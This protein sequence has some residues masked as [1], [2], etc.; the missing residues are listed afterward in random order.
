MS[1]RA[2]GGFARQR[3][4]ALHQH[5]ADGAQLRFRRQ[6]PV[7]VKLGKQQRQIAGGELRGGAPYAA[8]QFLALV[9]P[10]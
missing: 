10:G 9:G 8:S 1:Q 7:S 2:R 6:V 5:L 3:L 4:I